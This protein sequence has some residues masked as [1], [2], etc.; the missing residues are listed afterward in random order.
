MVASAYFPDLLYCH[1]CVYVLLL[2]CFVML[3][4]I[5]QSRDGFFSTS[6]TQVETLEED[7]IFM[8]LSLWKNMVSSTTDFVV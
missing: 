2:L 1:R 5:S 8:A 6:K 3:S 4:M 7:Y